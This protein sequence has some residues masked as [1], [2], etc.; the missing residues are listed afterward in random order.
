[1]AGIGNLGAL[2][3]PPLSKSIEVPTF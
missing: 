2:C 1:L 3:P